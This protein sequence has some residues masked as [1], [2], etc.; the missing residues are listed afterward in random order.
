M[1][2]TPKVAPQAKAKVLLPAGMD[3]A[4]AAAS[5]KGSLRLFADNTF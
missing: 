5:S 4:D 2:P 3:E 1:S